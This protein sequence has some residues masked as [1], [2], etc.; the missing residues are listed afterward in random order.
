MLLGHKQPVPQLELHVLPLGVKVALLQQ[1]RLLHLQPR[2]CQIAPPRLHEARRGIQLSLLRLVLRQ[3]LLPPGALQKQ[4]QVR[5]RGLAIHQL[6]R[7]V[8]RRDVHRIVDAELHSG[9][10]TG[11]VQLAGVHVGPQNSLHRLVRVLGLTVSLRMEGSG[12]RC[13]RSRQPQELRPEPRTEAGVP[14]TQEAGGHAVV[15]PPVVHEDARHVLS[16][17]LGVLDAHGDQSHHLGELVGD[18][19]DGVEALLSLR[20]PSDEVHGHHLEPPGRQRHWMQHPLGLVPTAV[21]VSLAGVTVGHV[22]LDVAAHPAPPAPTGDALIG[23]SHAQM[24]RRC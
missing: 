24:P 4:V 2:V 20:Q 21:L 15:L 23:L 10:M 3:L 18:G 14:V 6:E 19:Q 11:P 5:Q 9:E 7:R 17:A 8:A 13:L 22:V 16:R 1:L 12:H